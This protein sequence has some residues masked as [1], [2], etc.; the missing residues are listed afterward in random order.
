[1]KLLFCCAANLNRSPTFEDYFKKNHPEY[2]VRSAGI[3]A[4]YPY[5]VNEELCEWADIIYVMDLSQTMHFHY[6]Y[7]DHFQK[8]RTIGISDQYDR[9]D[10]ELIHLIEFWLKHIVDRVR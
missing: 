10:I 2:E 1:M 9:N 3:Y 5:Q 6:K 8:V 7:P 4:G